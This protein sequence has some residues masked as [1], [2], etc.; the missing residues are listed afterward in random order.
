MKIAYNDSINKNNKLLYKSCNLYKKKIE[1]DVKLRQEEIN[2][3]E[4]ALNNRTPE[5]IKKD[6]EFRKKL[7]E[8]EY[9][10]ETSKKD[11]IYI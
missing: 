2:K 8:N 9:I 3:R 5:E 4:I 7:S 6:K 1:N 10:N 11:I